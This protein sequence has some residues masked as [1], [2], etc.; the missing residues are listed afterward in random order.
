MYTSASK[1]YD[2]E[3]SESIL[4]LPQQIFIIFIFAEVIKMNLVKTNDK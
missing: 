3:S 2:E 1:K 4:C